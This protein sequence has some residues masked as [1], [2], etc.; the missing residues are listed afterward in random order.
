MDRKDAAKTRIKNRVARLNRLVAL[1]APVGILI[2]EVKLI[3]DACWLLDDAQAGQGLAN[4]QRDR[5]RHAAGFCIEDDCTAQA[6]DYYCADHQ[7]DEAGLD[8]NTVE[9]DF[10]EN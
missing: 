3:E 7:P 4:L 10:Q 8:P 6:K 5:V 9:D 1:D 2:R